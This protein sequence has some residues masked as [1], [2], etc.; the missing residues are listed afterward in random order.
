VG[1]LSVPS[2]ADLDGDGDLDAVVGEFGGTLRYFLNT[3]AGFTQ[4]VNVTAQNDPA[5]LSADVRNL[6]ETNAAAAISSSGTL[7]ITDP[8]S[9]TTAPMSWLLS[10]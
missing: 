3:G 10:M 7:T 9:P 5:V 6:T 8:D 2:F 1:L 4:V